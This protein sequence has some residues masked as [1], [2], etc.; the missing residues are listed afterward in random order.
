[1]LSNLCHSFAV[2]S[3]FRHCLIIFIESIESVDTLAILT[4]IKL[5][6]GEF[7]FQKFLKIFLACVNPRCFHGLSQ[8]NSEKKFLDQQMAN[9]K[10]VIKRL[11]FGTTFEIEGWKRLLPAREIFEKLSLDIDNYEL[12]METVEKNEFE[13]LYST[14]IMRQ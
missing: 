13:V 5:P 9:L 7:N 14:C 2:I 6:N 12:K 11:V 4:E 8:L 3:A 1:M 10:T